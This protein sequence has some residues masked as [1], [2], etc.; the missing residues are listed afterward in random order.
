MKKD[1]NFKKALN[2][3]LN[4]D[5]N[6][7]EQVSENQTEAVPVS[8]QTNEEKAQMDPSQENQLGDKS[9][10]EKPI[11]GEPIKE[12]PISVSDPPVPY[13]GEPDAPKPYTRIEK[14]VYEAI[15]TP[16]VVIKGDI[17]AGSNLRILGK[18]F[19]NVACEG[20]VVL[21]GNV[22]GD[23]SADKLRFIAG[24]IQGN[25]SVREHITT[26]RGTR[27][28]GDVNAG[29]AVLSGNV[30]GELNVH[31]NLELR[32]TSSVIGNIRALGIAIFNGSR[33]KGMMD[34][35]GDL[36]EMRAEDEE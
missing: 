36:K 29:S 7:S 4:L 27:I 30:Q 17:I 20:A 14:P 35:G 12:E 22:E 34:V 16:D 6:D 26:E 15:I 25:V 2:E 13:N 32:E 9:D 18:V 3:L 11:S 21:S 23:V 8:G 1:N 10:S 24:G 19:G 5:K 31:E 28:K 33:I